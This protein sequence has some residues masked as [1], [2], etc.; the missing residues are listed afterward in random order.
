MKVYL[1][2]AYS[3]PDKN[4]Q[5]QRFWLA[6]E[7]AAEIIK[8]G[9][10]CFSPI[11]HSHPIHLASDLPGDATFWGPLNKSWLEWC[12]EVWVMRIDGWKQSKGVKAEIEIAN[13]L[14]KKVVYL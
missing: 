10:F 5:Q 8:Q 9:H 13:K 4:V 2:C 12:D 7:H 1:A 11:S 14:G 6:N 3:H